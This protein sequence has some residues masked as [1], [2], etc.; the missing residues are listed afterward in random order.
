MRSAV[1]CT[2]MAQHSKLAQQLRASCERHPFCGDP[3]GGS[4]AAAAA[5][6]RK[7][8]E[9]S[10]APATASAPAPAPSHQRQGSRGQLSA[11]Q[12]AADPA[13]TA[14]AAAAPVAAAD[15]CTA[16]ALAHY[17]REDRALLLRALLHLADLSNPA[18]PLPMGAT[19]GC[20][21][22]KEFLTQVR[23]LSVLH[24]ECPVF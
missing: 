10:A 21:V 13:A 8:P 16:Q 14:A 20:L 2:D 17:S 9:P 12:H 15:A 19:W 3:A 6:S 18:R 5:G 4:A 22:A 11:P 7:R 24:L 1:L 23:L